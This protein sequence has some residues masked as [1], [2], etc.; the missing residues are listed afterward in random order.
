MPE[1]KK[2]KAVS[3]NSGFFNSKEGTHDRSY[4]AEDISKIFDGIIQDGVYND[5]GDRFFVKSKGGLSISIGSGRAWFDHTWFVNE[6]TIITS[7]DEPIPNPAMGRYDAI[8]IEVN[9]NAEIR[10]TRLVYI[11]GDGGYEYSKPEMIKESYINQYP[12]AYIHFKPGTEEITDADIEIVVGTSECPFVTGI[13]EHTDIDD[14]LA[15]WNIEAEKVIT[16]ND[17]A[18]QEW[19]ASTRE[20]LDTDVAG[21]LQNEIDLLNSRLDSFGNAEDISY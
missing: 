13:L 5:V 16:E 4:N 9:A 18:F 21:H 15:G 3:A 6:S 20:H 8:A 7:T 11:T 2:I 14:L 12:V 1:T 17:E 19:F 10:E